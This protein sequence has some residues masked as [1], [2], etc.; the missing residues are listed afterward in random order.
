[1]VVWGARRELEGA[2]P[3]AEDAKEGE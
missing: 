1:V 2:P 3:A